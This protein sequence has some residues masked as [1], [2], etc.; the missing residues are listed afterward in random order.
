MRCPLYRF[1]WFERWSSGEDYRSA[2]AST[3]NGKS[4]RLA[5]YPP[6]LTPYSSIQIIV[7]ASPSA[8]D[9]LLAACS[10]I[11]TMTKDVF[12]PG[13][14]EVVQIGQH[15]QNFAIQLSDEL[16]KSIKMSTVSLPI[17]SS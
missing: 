7:H 14:R 2:S 6:N 4:L 8:T 1:G 9:A 13:E 17:R 10:N 3:Q 15:T 11:R 12:A 5:A 16:I